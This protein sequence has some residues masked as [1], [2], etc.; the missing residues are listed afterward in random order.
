MNHELD[1]VAAYQSPIYV[2]LILNDHFSNSRIS[3][4]DKTETTSSTSGPV[5]HDGCLHHVP[6]GTKVLLQ[7]LFVCVP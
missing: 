3:K 2:M 7:S 1:C 4:D 6:I 5:L